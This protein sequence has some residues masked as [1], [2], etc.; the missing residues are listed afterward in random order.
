MCFS[1]EV[2]K[3]YWRNFT[4]EALLWRMFYRPPRLRRRFS[5]LTRTKSEERPEEEG[6]RLRVTY[7]GQKTASR[8][9][10]RICLLIFY[11]CVSI[12]QGCSTTWT[13]RSQSRA[14]PRWQSQWWLRRKWRLSRSARGRDSAKRFFFVAFAVFSPFSS[15]EAEVWDEAAAPRRRWVDPTKTVDLLKTTACGEKVDWHISS[16]EVVLRKF[17]WWICIGKILQENFYWRSFTEEILLKKA[18]LE[19]FYWR[20]FTEEGFTEE[21]LLKKALLEKFYWRNFTEEILLKKALLEKFYWRNFTEEILLKK[22][23]LETWT[24]E[25]VAAT[26]AFLVIL[27]WVDG[28]TLRKNPRKEYVYSRMVSVEPLF[29]FCKP[30]EFNVYD[31]LWPCVALHPAA[32]NT[33]RIPGS[34]QVYIRLWL[35]CKKLLLRRNPKRKRKATRNCVWWHTQALSRMASPHAS[36]RGWPFVVSWTFTRRWCHQQD[37]RKRGLGG[38]VHKHTGWWLLPVCSTI[39]S[40]MC[41]GTQRSGRH[42]FVLPWT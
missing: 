34:E 40:K 18:L 9:V 37:A 14:K 6:K 33:K 13:S 16:T 32:A 30:C 11:K 35:L 19:K 12:W 15:Q 20:N 31:L 36:Q 42:T 3:F 41:A 8:F 28:K 26:A 39:S 38:P 17:Y 4:A 1:G 24:L 23:L 21:I 29:F 10:V 27:I 22:A 7:L 5:Q 2:D 25:C